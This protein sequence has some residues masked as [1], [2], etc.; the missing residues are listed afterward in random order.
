MK[1]KCEHRV[2]LAARAIEILK[3]A[4]ELSE[5][6]NTFFRAA[7]LRSRFAT[8]SSRKCCASRITTTSRDWCE[9]KTNFSNSVIEAALAAHREEQ[10]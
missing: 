7:G 1:A 10:G 2:P 5:E 9:E 4:K 3:A 6:G 8:W